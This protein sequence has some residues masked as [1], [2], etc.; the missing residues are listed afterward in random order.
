MGEVGAS[1]S[2]PAQPLPLPRDALSTPVVP[3]LKHQQATYHT[4][5]INE[6]RDTLRRPSRDNG[7]MPQYG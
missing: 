5:P 2:L 7:T 4:N 6:L 1:S 3:V